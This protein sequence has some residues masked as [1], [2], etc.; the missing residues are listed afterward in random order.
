MALRSVSLEEGQ[1]QP[2]ERTRAQIRNRAMEGTPKQRRDC[3]AKEICLTLEECE[4]SSPDRHKNE[5]VPL[6]NAM[7]RQKS[8]PWNRYHQMTTVGPVAG[9][10]GDPKLLETP[11]QQPRR[12]QPLERRHPRSDT[13]DQ[14]PGPRTRRKKLTEYS[15]IKKAMAIKPSGGSGATA[16]CRGNHFRDDKVPRDLQAPEGPSQHDNSEHTQGGRASDSW[17]LLPCSSRNRKSQLPG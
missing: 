10:T 8:Q 3:D 16:R 13:A 6:R 15:T 12:N 17:L 14:L 9:A 7:A 2:Q 1:R 4:D 5:E 11:A